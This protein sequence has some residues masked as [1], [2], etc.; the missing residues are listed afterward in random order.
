MWPFR[1]KASSLLQTCK[2]CGQSVLRG[3]FTEFGCQ[4]CA[5]EPRV[6]LR[7]RSGESEYRR[8]CRRERWL[9]W[10]D[11]DWDEVVEPERNLLRRMEERS[12]LQAEAFKP[13]IP[14]EYGPISPI[15]LVA[16]HR[17]MVRY[18]ERIEVEN[19]GCVPDWGEMDE[20]NYGWGRP[21]IQRFGAFPI[22]CWAFASIAI[23]TVSG[24]KYRLQCHRAYADA[25]VEALQDAWRTQSERMRVPA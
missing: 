12:F 8:N 19:A 9:K 22:A 10:V 1:R 5:P 15:L 14:I 18:V 11:E 2:Q 25:W 16:G 24:Q 21:I 3:D 7:P 20:V 23:S 13:V 6:D 4:F 17:I